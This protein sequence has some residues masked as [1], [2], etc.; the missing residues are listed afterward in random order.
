MRKKPASAKLILYGGGKIGQMIAAFLAD[1]GDY[2]VTVADRSDASLNAFADLNVQRKQVDVTN[3]AELLASAKGQ[4]FIINACPYM[5][6]PS[7][8]RAAKEAGAHYFDL[9]EDV[10]NTRIVKDLAK[11]A[12]SAFMPQC[13]L[14]PGFVSIA[15]NYLAQK[16]DAI[17]ELRMR[18]GALPKYPTNALKYNLTWSTDGLIN[19]YCQL[20]D[21]IVDGAQIKLPPLEGLEHFAIEGVDYEA[22]NTS[23][24]LGTLCESLS[25][26]AQNLNYKSIRYPGH[27]DIMRFL[28][29][30]LKLK[31]RQELLKEIFENAI[32]ATTQDTVLV[33]NTALGKKMDAICRK[34]TRPVSTPKNCSDKNAALSRFPPPQA[35]A[36]P[37]ICCA[38]GHCRKKALCVRNK[39]IWMYS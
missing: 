2:D 17:E 20:C 1:C 24:G 31:E 7:I 11:D 29:S 12:K 16:F 10:A 6:A 13:G 4:D 25:G 38:K 28:L 8:A 22:F 34:F 9:T 23:G 19:E 18:V 32:P 15:A 27:R 36:P 14:A 39:L 21:A 33:F 26:K 35:F 5:F 3:D 37:L 30:D